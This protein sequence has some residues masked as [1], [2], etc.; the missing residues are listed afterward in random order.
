ML[1]ERIKELR[2][3]RGITQVELAKALFVSKQSVSNWENDNI[4]PSVDMLV[5]IAD[6]FGVSTDYMLSRES[7]TRISVEGLTQTQI[8]HINAIIKDIVQK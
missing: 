1:N 8:Q 3:A 7:E 4:L 6:Y 2:E 5:K